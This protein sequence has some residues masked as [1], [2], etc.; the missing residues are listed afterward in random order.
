MVADFQRRLVELRF[1]DGIEKVEHV[2]YPSG[3]EFWVRFSRQLDMK[4]LEEIARKHGAVL[5]RFGGL[6]SKLPRP[7]AEILWD[8][9]NHVIAKN[10]GGWG[11]FTAALGF[12]P[13]GIAK[14]ASD[15]HG[16]YQIFIATQEEGV[17]ILYE[18][19]GLKY[20]APAPP[21]KPVAPP[22]PPTAAVVKP[23]APAPGLAA[24]TAPLAPVPRAPAQPAQAAPA[25]PAGP[26]PVSGTTIPKGQY[27]PHAWGQAVTTSEEKPPPSKSTEEKAPQKETSGA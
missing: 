3:D 20:V 21:A 22:K 25:P 15:A 2:P 9:V 24:P 4:K 12:E 5:V 6:P 19:L 10:I 23:V 11:K 26:A 13:D 7:L 27:R 16:P 18:Y 8:G 17:Q 1:V 14:V